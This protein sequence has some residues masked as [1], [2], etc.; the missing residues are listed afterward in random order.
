M[1]L[2]EETI[3]QK[4]KVYK[5]NDTINDFGDYDDEHRKYD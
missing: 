4:I 5:I 1:G 2:E 3:S